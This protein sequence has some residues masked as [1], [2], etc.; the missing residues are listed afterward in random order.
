MATNFELYDICVKTLAAYSPANNSVS[1]LGVM[2]IHEACI[3]VIH[4]HFAALDRERRNTLK[5]VLFEYSV[6]DGLINAWWHYYKHDN[7]CHDLTITD[8]VN[9]IFIHDES[10]TIL[11]AYSS[12]GGYHIDMATLALL[13]EMLNDLLP[14]KMSKSQKK[15]FNNCLKRLESNDEFHRKPSKNGFITNHEAYI[16]IVYNYFN[17]YEFSE[18]RRDNLKRALLNYAVSD[19]TIKSL[20]HDY[21][22]RCHGFT[23]EDYVNNVFLDEKRFTVDNAY[24]NNGGYDVNKGTLALVREMML[25][26]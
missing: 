20:W 19:S 21:K 25:A 11:E 12:N 17:T 5:T 7:E 26:L 8:Y 6:S 24:T 18:C 15:H 16:T 2:S 14:K 10:V 4:N 23:I 22:N 1:D 3:S 9:K 13:R